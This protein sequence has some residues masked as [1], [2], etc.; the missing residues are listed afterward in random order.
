VSGTKYSV[1]PV[2]TKN[3]LSRSIWAALSTTQ[4]GEKTTAS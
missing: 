3:A 2:L 4:F 1:G